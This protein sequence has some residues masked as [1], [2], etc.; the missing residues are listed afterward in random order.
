MEPKSQDNKF[1]LRK[2][3]TVKQ[4]KNIKKKTGTKWNERK[5]LK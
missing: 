2:Y 3:Y 5:T 4:Q 1:S